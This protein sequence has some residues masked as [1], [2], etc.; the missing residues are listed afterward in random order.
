MCFATHTDRH[1]PNISGVPGYLISAFS[2]TEVQEALMKEF[3]A[4]AHSQASLQSAKL[5]TQKEALRIQSYWGL[6][7][8]CN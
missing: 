3:S 1:E 8:S 4:H 6:T 2:D 5:S 7:L